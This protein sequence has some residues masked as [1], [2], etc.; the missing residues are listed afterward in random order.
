M[1]FNCGKGQDDILMSAESAITQNLKT[2]VESGGSIYASDFA[3]LY[4]E[5]PWPDAIEF[6]GDDTVVY[7]PKVGGVGKLTAKVVDPV[8]AAHLGKDHVQLN[9]DEGL[10]AV[11]ESAAADTKVHV[12]GNMSSPLATVSN[13]PLLLTHKPGT[14]KVLYTSFHNEAQVTADMEAILQYL[15][16]EL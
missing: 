14:G 5:W 11:A 7:G 9:F 15:V 6:F 8:L 10:W 3:F 2:F 16:F 4:V 1:F 12:S 13:A